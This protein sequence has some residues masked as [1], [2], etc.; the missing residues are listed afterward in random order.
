MSNRSFVQVV[1][2]L[3][4]LLL[5]GSCGGG[6]GGGGSGGSSNGA[7]TILAPAEGAM[8]NKV[9]VDLAVRVGPGAD[10]AALRVLLDGVDISTR[11]AAADADGVRRAAVDRPALNL[12]KNQLRATAGTHSAGA[13]FIVNLGG[14]VAAAGA[15]LPSLVPIRTRVVSGNGSAAT[16]YAVALY[17]DPANPDVATPVR[18]ATPSDGSNAGFQIVYLQRSD[19]TALRNITVPALSPG[20]DIFA[21][22][23]GAALL[24]P[25]STCG[26]AG[27]LVIVQS[28]RTMG[29]MPC[30]AD[31]SST[32]CE[33]WSE[34]F[35]SLG[36][37]AR[38]AYANGS[39]PQVAY[40]FIGNVGPTGPNISNLQAGTFY[41]RLSC[42]GSNYGSAPVC[43]N[44]G[45][46]NTSFSAPA[47]AAPSQLGAMAGALVRDNYS[48]YT[49]VQ[50]AAP[51]HFAS[52]T[53][54]KALTHTITVDGV[55]YT[56][57]PLGGAS[58]GFHLLI[59]NRSDLS[60][61]QH[62]TFA[63]TGDGRDVTALYQA[64]TGYKEYRSLFFVAAFGN[65]AYTG[66][67]ASRQ[68]WYQASTLMAQLGGTQQVFYLLNNSGA[69]PQPQDSY[70]LVGS[71][72]DQSRGSVFGTGLENRYG[73]ELSSVISRAT[74]RYPLPTDMEGLLVM[75]H[76]GF[77]D[78][79]PT[80][81]NLGLS[82]VTAAE[83][84]SASLRDPIAWPLPGPDP[85][86]SLAAY[87]WISQQL[88]CDDIRATYANLNTSPALWLAGLLQLSYDPAKLPN[89]S[90]ADFNAVME[91]LRTEFMYV[92]LLR[93]FQGNVQALYQDQQANVSLLL[94][95]AFDEI[96]ANLDVVLSTPV[97]PPQ[98]TTMLKDVFG[99]LG[100]GTALLS[101]VMG[102]EGTVAAS[103]V[104]AG[105][106]FAL[107]V[108]TMIGD[109]VASQTNSAAGTPLQ[110]QEQEMVAAASLA[111]TAADNYAATLVTLGGQFDRIVGDWGRLKTLGAPLLAGQVPWDGNAAGMVLQGYDRLVRRQYVTQLLKAVS[112][113]NY[114]PYISD[115]SDPSDSSYNN[116]FCPWR[117]AILNPGNPP[118][119]LLFYPSGAVNNDTSSLGHGTAYP[120]DYQWG[121][122]AL[123]VARHGNDDCVPNISGTPYPATFGLFSPLDPA[124]SNTLGQFPL[125]FFTRQG[126]QT[127]TNNRNTPCYDTSAC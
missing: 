55:P 17:L 78:P 125:W 116:D 122:W 117:N 85:D 8:L 28:L 18:A 24:S 112:V 46:P 124:D 105:I 35:M 44:L 84:L 99:L 51:V 62:Q 111:S 63:A 19:L 15:A 61:Q 81:H 71:F 23:L 42:S 14:R 107:S 82:S 103:G 120:Y 108:G 36:G 59:L 100:T 65:T 16:D 11:F 95:Q 66:G 39:N 27:C 92:A 93:Q 1:V 34:M 77:Y 29:Y 25:P 30:F 86:R 10:P 33:Y 48:N 121:V 41:E 98:W 123:V 37:S 126:Y 47:N 80:G 69:N 90:A 9:P 53:D 2:A 5:L 73:A 119:P 104:S 67:D 91:Q 3:C 76:Q 57:T 101:L 75:N 7:V 4:A 83:V 21:S 60:L 89:S 106:G 12:G 114:Y 74:Q 102:P 13:T 31:P 70:M 40:S 26:S 54:S 118:V 94:Q 88:C 49:Y 6:G 58:G 113:V 22:E 97:Q 87:N 68:A 72:V 96:T 20:Q 32:D 110:A 127:Y 52:Q 43:D 38:N 79:G 109:Q 45:F 64:I 56:S 115:T 50:N